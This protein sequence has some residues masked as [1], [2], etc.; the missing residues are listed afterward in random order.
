MPPTDTLLS[1]IRA[2]VD[3]PASV[4]ELVKVLRI[5]RDERPSLRRQLKQLVASGAL[6]ETRGGHYGVPERMDLVVGRLSMSQNGFGFVHP[7]RA[8]DGVPHEVYVSGIHLNEAMHGDRVLARIERRDT[9]ERPEGRVLRVMERAQS[10]LVGRY[11]IDAAGLR[12]VVPLDRR[13]TMDVIVREGKS[14][15]RSQGRWSPS[16]S[17]AG[18]RP[19]AVPSARSSSA[20]GASTRRAWT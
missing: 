20:S 5:P 12:F 8:A 15:R 18:R 3:H 16:R 10:S 19:P 14:G 6:V 17:P 13:V 1:R 7:D 11:E 4:A 2:A 9:G